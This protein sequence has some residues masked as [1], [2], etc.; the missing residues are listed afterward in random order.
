MRG[1]FDTEA[2]ALEI[3]LV[4]SEHADYAEIVDKSCCHV[5]MVGDEAVNISLL[6]PRKHL[7]LLSV[8]AERYELDAEELLATAQAALAAPD[9]LVEVSIGKSLVA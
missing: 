9:H 5:H 4:R 3:D 8:V 6:T 2:N 1:D 7:D